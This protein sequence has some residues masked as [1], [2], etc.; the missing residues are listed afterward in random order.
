[1]NETPKTVMQNQ[2][3]HTL[4]KHKS[5]FYKKKTLLTLYFNSLLSAF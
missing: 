2:K 3:R 5:L 1:M 4:K